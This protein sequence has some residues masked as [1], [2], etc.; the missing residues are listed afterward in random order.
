[1]EKYT[2]GL[3]TSEIFFGKESEAGTLFIGACSSDVADLLPAHDLLLFAHLRPRRGWNRE[4]IPVRGS[5]RVS[6]SWN[7]GSDNSQFKKLPG[8][9]MSLSA[10]CGQ[11]LRSRIDVESSLG[12]SVC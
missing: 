4:L 8:I 2:T 3:P 11:L 10:H 7:G 12:S 5:L 9:K 1:M 6:S